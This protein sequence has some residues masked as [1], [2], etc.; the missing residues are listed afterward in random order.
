MLNQH[1]GNIKLI[2]VISDRRK[3]KMGQLR[4][5]KGSSGKAVLRK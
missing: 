3:R 4:L 5:I 1:A 2:I